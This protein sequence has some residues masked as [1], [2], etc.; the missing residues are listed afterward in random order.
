MPRRTCGRRTYKLLSISRPDVRPGWKQRTRKRIL[1]KSTTVPSAKTTVSHS[2]QLPDKNDLSCQKLELVSLALS[3][4][5]C[6]QQLLL[7]RS[8]MPDKSSI[9]VTEPTPP[10]S[11]D[12]V[13]TN[14]ENIMPPIDH[15]QPSSNHSIR[16]EL[17]DVVKK[18]QAM[19]GTIR[20]ARDE[21][22]ATRRVQS[23]AI[24]QHESQHE[25]DQQTIKKLQDQAERYRQE[26]ND[27]WETAESYL[28]QRDKALDDRNAA[29]ETGEDWV[30]ERDEAWEREEDLTMRLAH[31]R[32]VAR[33]AMMAW[34][35]RSRLTETWAV[36]HGT[37]CMFPWHGNAQGL[38]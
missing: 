11:E 26:R 21:I 1:H 2:Q 28:V 19:L 12:E 27:A 15:A 3:Q 32:R 24:A 17:H 14:N 31:L 36:C 38:Q 35:E 16:A 25:T 4:S 8:K 29:Y 6:K 13:D 18:T 9:V 22:R 37:C 20:F 7:L 34:V 33:E 10:M 30:L 23:T 5:Y